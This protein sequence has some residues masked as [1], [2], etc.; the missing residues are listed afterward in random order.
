MSH[1]EFPQFADFPNLGR[2]LRLGLATRGNTSLECEDVL[3]AVERGVNY[4]NWCGHPDGMQ[5]AIRQ[6]GPRRKNLFIASQF[7]ARTAT[8]ARQELAEVLTALSTDYIDVATYYYVE[9]QQEWD[10]ITAPGGAAEVLESARDAGTVRAIGLTSHQ[11]KLAAACAETNR[12]NMLMIRYNAAHRGAEQDIFPTTTN[13]QLPVVVF[14]CL[15]WG[16]L[17]QNTADDPEGFVAPPA[18]EWY[19]FALCHPA[20]TVALMAPNGREEL[21]QNLQLLEDWRGFT[22]DQYSRLKEH[23]ARVRQHGGQFP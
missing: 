1:D 10:E 19:R 22:P 6:L 14:T 23:G 20:V 12:L 5:E 18:A 16:A 11:R 4:L 15:R 21:D 7:S 9:H 13:L 3:F 2:T 17:M 8:A